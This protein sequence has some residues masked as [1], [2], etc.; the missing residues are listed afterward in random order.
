[1]TTEKIAAF[2]DFDQTLLAKDS[3][4]LGFKWAWENRKVSFGFLLKIIIAAKL[5]RRNWLSAEKI[6][7]MAMKFYRGQNMQEFYEGADGYYQEWLKPHLAPEILVKVDEH[8]QAGHVLVILSASVEYLLQAVADDLGFDHLLA[9]KV[10]VDENG[11]GTGR[12]IGSVCI[13]VH[14]RTCALQL[15]EQENIDL[16]QSYAYGDHHSDLPLLESVGH[17]VAVR[18]TAPLRETAT[19]RNW[20]IIGE[21]T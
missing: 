13:G 14:K 11:R 12:A 20:P 3:A 10:E 1:M 5:Y 2:F 19:A 9:T 17:P 21:R 18:P 15:A 7:T 6:S 8:R 4:E 16:A